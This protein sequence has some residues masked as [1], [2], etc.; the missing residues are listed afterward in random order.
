M[1]ISAVSSYFTTLVNNLMEL[2]RQPLYR[3]KAEQSAVN[4]QKTDYSSV[5]TK[6]GELE[7]TVDALIKTDPF[8][9]LGTGRSV[10][11]SSQ[12]A[13]T[14]VASATA[15][16]SVVAGVYELSVSYL[17]KAQQRNSDTPQSSADL[18]L[19][20]TG[21]FKL[22]GTGTASA[23][24][25]PNTSVL[26][27]DDA[28]VTS[29]LSELGTSAA[30]KVEIRD[31]DG[32]FKFRLKNDDGQAVAIDDLSK[33]GSSLT[34]D[35]QTVTA[36]DID[37]GRGL[38]IKFSGTVSAGETTVGYTA[39]GV[40]VQVSA[41][42]SLISIAEKINSVLQPE[43]RA[44]AATVVGTQ[45]VLTAKQTGTNH[46]MIYEDNVGLGF[47][48]N[49]V[50][51]S[52]D[53][54]KARNA[55]FSVN[56]IAFTR[57]TNSGLTDIVSGLTL[58]LA[59]DAEGKSATIQIS[60]DVSGARTAV[61]SF[62]AKFNDL[63]T[64]LEQK[65]SVTNDGTGSYIRGSLASDTIFSDLRMDLFSQYMKDVPG[66]GM[67]KSLRDIGLGIDDNL[68]A[69]ITDSSKLDAAL[70]NNLDDVAN[71]LEQAMGSLKT[72]LSRFTGT[73]GYIEE[74]LG[75]LDNQVKDYTYQIKDMNERLV[76][77]ETSLS[78]QYAQMQSQLISMAYMQETWAS[79]SASVSQYT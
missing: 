49:M 10:K 22:G 73:S 24:S 33:T 52:V 31:F 4:T 56:N 27:V 67:L 42:D 60:N 5:K 15:S 74:S 58:N 29:G 46:R 2:E 59:A 32:V 26:L 62:L 13:D 6:L 55:S 71:L 8:S 41:T 19:G 75:N 54:Q 16:S 48:N 34:S 21:T 68:K 23:T 50:D 14:T 38:M 70:Q 45:L 72:T 64:Y 47:S 78:N 1:D 7:G 30:Y 57:S 17:A 40:S 3:L 76:D 61:E 65:T 39:A 20:K 69:N 35:W 53:V 44:V 12:T 9:K 18:A 28:V 36:G 77:R 43:G 66:S 11:L 51:D 37:T 25:T 63:Q 79:I